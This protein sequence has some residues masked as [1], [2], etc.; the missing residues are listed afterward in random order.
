MF[1][2]V[3]FAGLGI[4][5]DDWQQVLG[6]GEHFLLDDHPQF[7]VAEPGRVLAVVVGPGA[8]DEVDDFVA[9]ILRIADAGRFFDFLQFFVQRNAVEDF[10]GFRVAVFLVLDPEVGV[11]HITIEDVLAVLAVGLEVGGLDLLADEFDV[12]RCQV[13]LEEAQIAFAGL[14]LELFLLDL[15]FQHVE[16]VH[17]VGGNFVRVEVEHLRQDLEREAGRQTVHAFVD[18]R[19]VAVFLD[20]LGFRIGVLEVLA[21]VH[22]HLRV[23]VGVFRLLEAREHGELGQHLQGVRRAMCLGQRTVEQ[24]LVVDLHF[25]TDPQAVRHFDDVD[26]VDEGFVVLVVAEGVPLRFVGVRQQD[27]GERNRAE[28]FGTVVVAFLGGGQQWV[29]HLDRCL[30]HFDEFHQALVGP[31]QG[32]RVAVGVGV[33]LREL[34]QFADI[35]LAHQRRDVLVVFVTRFGFGHGDLVED[36]RVEFH[37]AELADVAAEFGQAFGGPWRHD[38][39]EVAPR[40]AEIFLEDRAIFSGVEQTQGRFEY[41]RALDRVEGHSFHQLLE[42]FGQGRF[43]TADGAE[44]I[45]DLFLLFQALGGMAEIRHDLVDAFFHPVEVFKGRIATDHL[46]GEDA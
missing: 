35:D 26:P 31:A 11:Q 32:A 9:E 18:A 46:V 6:V 44:Q 37:H 40:D 3:L 4:E 19:I 25:V 41:R 39:V 43:T 24:Q 38:G 13:L 27:P 45:K 5:A 23:D 7:F 17:R 21:V 34:L 28:A 20:R 2:L 36:R 22:A 10:A 15:L 1:L 14:G 30:E 12:T 33:V 42:F 16:Q 29:Q 8:Q